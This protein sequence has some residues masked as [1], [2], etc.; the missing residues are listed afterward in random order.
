MTCIKIGDLS[1][2][3]CH[4]DRIVRGIKRFLMH[5]TQP[6]VNC[7]VRNIFKIDHI[8]SGWLLSG[9]CVSKHDTL[10]VLTWIIFSEVFTE[11]KCSKQAIRVMEVLSKSCFHIFRG[12]GFFLYNEN[13]IYLLLS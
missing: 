7:G 10:D 9:A 12:L 8:V 2:K 3:R 11:A 5:M 1:S 4:F 13:R 6:Y